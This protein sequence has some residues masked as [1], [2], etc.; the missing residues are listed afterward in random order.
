M[1]KALLDM[2]P[3]GVNEP[4]PGETLVA[5]GWKY[6]DYIPMAT[7]LWDLLLAIIGDGNYRLVTP[8]QERLFPD[9]PRVYKRAQMFISPT[10]IVNIAAY[11]ASA[12]RPQSRENR[13]WHSIFSGATRAIWSI[14]DG[15]S[16]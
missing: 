10:G 2:N 14:V 16:K 13:I 8:V 4:F 9:D 3:F 15:P 1:D 11:A 7:E 6:H 12:K 5:D